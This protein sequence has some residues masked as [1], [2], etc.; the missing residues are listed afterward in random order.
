MTFSAVVAMALTLALV[1]ALV[2]ITMRLLRRLTHGS[3]TSRGAM[4]LA[5][6]RFRVDFFP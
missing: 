6:R 5:V 2:A 3:V 1:L 4:P